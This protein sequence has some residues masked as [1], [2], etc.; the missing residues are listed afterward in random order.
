MKTFL[1]LSLISASLFVAS[2]N[3]HTEEDEPATA[4]FTIST[5]V[6]NQVYNY[7]DTVKIAGTISADLEMHG[8]NVRLVNLST[9]MNVLNNG[10]HAHGTSF[11]VNESWKNTVSDTTQMK[12]II[13][14]A[15]DHDGNLSTLERTITCNGQ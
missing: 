11:V 10:Y 14:A 9:G 2:C 6:E 7:G 1:Y 15:I 3:K 8:Y 4:V 5:P 13:D 12:I